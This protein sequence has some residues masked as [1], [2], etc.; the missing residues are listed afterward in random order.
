[1]I[2]NLLFEFKNDGFNRIC[3]KKNL[4]KKKKYCKLKYPKM[5]EKKS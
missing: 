1:M 2:I 3:F 5:D 4:N